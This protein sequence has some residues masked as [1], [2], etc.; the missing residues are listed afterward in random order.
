MAKKTTTN[1]GSIPDCR[2]SS[3]TRI[4]SPSVLVFTSQTS[5]YL[6][7]P[8]IFSNTC[9]I[10]SQIEG[11]PWLK[12]LQVSVILLHIRLVVRRLSRNTPS[13]RCYLFLHVLQTD[14]QRRNSETLKEKA[15]ERMKRCVLAHMCSTS[16]QLGQVATGPQTTARCEGGRLRFHSFSSRQQI[17]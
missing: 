16:N 4:W 5:H 11:S 13:G 14:L 8:T 1:H 3:R 12:A 17:S 10:G 9:N 15:R 2:I 6:S 7:S